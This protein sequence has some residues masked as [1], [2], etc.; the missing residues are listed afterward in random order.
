MVL[1][2]LTDELRDRLDALSPHLPLELRQRVATLLGPTHLDHHQSTTRQAETARSQSGGT[3][4][5]PLLVDVSAW[6]KSHGTP[7]QR[8]DSPRSQYQSCNIP[9]LPRRTDHYRLANL[10]RLTDVYAPPLPERV[11]V[12]GCPPQNLASTRPGHSSTGHPPVPGT[13]RH[14]RRYPTPPR[15]HRLLIH[16]LARARTSPVSHPPARPLRRPRSQRRRTD[17]IGRGRVGRD[18][19]RIGR[20]RQCRREYA[21]GRDRRL[22]GRRRTELR[23]GEFSC[24]VSFSH[25][26]YALK[27]STDHHYRLNDHAASLPRPR[28]CRRDRRDRRFPLLPLLLS[29]I[30]QKGSRSSVSSDALDPEA[31]RRAFFGGAQREQDRY[32]RSEGDSGSEDGLESRTGHRHCICCWYHRDVKNTVYYHNS[33]ENETEESRQ[34]N[35]RDAVEVL[36]DLGLSLQ[37]QGVEVLLQPVVVHLDANGEVQMNVSWARGNRCRQRGNG[38]GRTWE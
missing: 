24:P 15:P 26:A 4:P 9:D 20:D 30:C 23:R 37:R 12:S 25:G 22:V 6:T 13:A 28:R 3:V 31:S 11:K 29:P 35:E 36:G 14:P 17:Q 19:A 33:L 8:G 18:Q 7:E 34:E 2:E 21:G 27:A 5:H 16:D 1:L 32:A 38:E 10:L